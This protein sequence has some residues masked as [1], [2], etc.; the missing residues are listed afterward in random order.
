MTNLPAS[1]ITE[2]QSLLQHRLAVIA[3][4]KLRTEEPEEQLRQLQ[5]VSEEINTWHQTYHHRIDRNLDHFLTGCSYQKALDYLD[6]GV[7]RP[8]GT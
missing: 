2:L 7:R 1:A 3:N 4:E 8:C 6:S 5:Q